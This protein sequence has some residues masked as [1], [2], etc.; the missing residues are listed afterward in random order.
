MIRNYEINPVDFK[1]L[2]NRK[3][4]GRHALNRFPYSGQEVIILCTFP[5]I[6]VVTGRGTGKSEVLIADDTIFKATVKPIFDGWMYGLKKPLTS[7]TIILG[8]IKSTAKMSQNNIKRGFKSSDFLWDMVEHA[9]AEYMRTKDG[10]EISIKTASDSA[11]GVHATVELD[12]K[13]MAIKHPIYIKIDEV[14]FIDNKD[15]LEAVLEPMLMYGGPGSQLAGYTTPYGQEGP[16]WEIYSDENNVHCPQKYTI[17]KRTGLRTYS[18][19][20]ELCEVCK[21]QN[22]GADWRIFQLESYQNPY[23]DRKQLVGT[24]RRLIRTGKAVIWN[25][26][27]CGVPEA[28]AGLFFTRSHI[29]Q[30]T[31]QDKNM[32]LWS[33]E[34]ILLM[35]PQPGEWLIGIDDNSGIK[36]KH[37][38]YASLAIGK[39]E[40]N[41]CQLKFII[42]IRYGEIPHVFPYIKRGTL[43]ETTLFLIELTRLLLKQKLVGKAKVFIDFGYGQAIM[44]ALENEFPNK[45][46]Y[47]KNSGLEIG[48][49]FL[50]MRTLIE[51]DRFKMPGID[52]VIDECKYL[53]GLD[54]HA[55]DNDKLKIQ[56]ARSSWGDKKT[57]DGLFAIAYM[58]KGMMGAVVHLR[59][60]T[61]DRDM[62]LPFNLNSDPLKIFTPV[63]SDQFNLTSVNHL[64]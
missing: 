54:E 9:T 14:W 29:I 50:N 35:D 48:Q 42:R 37:A 56:K 20:R 36:S 45:L 60:G 5:K 8:N 26:E 7:K 64:N 52:W 41:A 10:S 11:R 4:F 59:G 33:I 18:F 13:G 58:L 61:I 15:L 23:A 39:R 63:G 51:T 21:A 55:E 2:Y 53:I 25:Q 47:V 19:D 1:R 44:T 3:V 49:C 31:N 46:E 27:Y 40:G 22:S 6:L 34:E 28:S 57:V 62:R 32:R 30:M 38:D 16:G 24:K 12:E 43:S 17:D